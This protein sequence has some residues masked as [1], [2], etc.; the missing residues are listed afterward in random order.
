MEKEEKIELTPEEKEK[1]ERIRK[2]FER[3]ERARRE[4]LRQRAMR[5]AVEMGEMKKWLKL[6]LENLYEKLK[7]K[8]KDI[9]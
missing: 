8:L 2:A 3:V 5:K 9:L 4:Y 1:L 6:E 7:Y